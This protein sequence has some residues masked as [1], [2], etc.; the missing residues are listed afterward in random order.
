MERQVYSAAVVGCGAGGMLSV[1]ALAASDH[2]RLVAVCDLRSE[3]RDALVREFPGIRTYADH[4]ALLSDVSA[5]VVCVSTYPPTHEEIALAALETDPRGLLV[6]KPLGH[7]TAAGRR[8]LDAV[9]KR[10]KPLAV[11]HG[12]V[13]RATSLEVLR[14]VRAGEI[15]ELRLVEIENAGWDIINAGIHWFQFFVTLIG[16]DPFAGVLAACDT[17]SRTFRDGM[18][19]ETE[20]VTRTHGRGAA[21]GSSCTAATALPPAG[22]AR[23]PCSGSSAPTV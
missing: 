20:A 15:G 18:R 4:R 9:A 1:K 7:S 6:E 12:L 2:Y 22:P 17:S 11:P 23:T 19:V 16:A 3:V 8:I 14:R 5:D 21:P 13:A 10:R